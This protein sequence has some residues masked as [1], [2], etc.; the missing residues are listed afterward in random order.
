MSNQRTTLLESELDEIVEVL[1][2]FPIRSVHTRLI[3]CEKPR[4]VGEANSF[5]EVENEE[6]SDDVVIARSIFDRFVTR[7][8]HGEVLQASLELIDHVESIE[9][10]V[11]L[12][13][14]DW[15]KAHPC[16]PPNICD[17]SPA[18]DLPDW[19]FSNKNGQFSLNFASNIK[20]VIESAVVALN[21][22]QSMPEVILTKTAKKAVFRDVSWNPYVI[23]ATTMADAEQFPY[24][25]NEQYFAW[26]YLVR[27]RVGLNGDYGYKERLN[28]F[29]GEGSS[30]SSLNISAMMNSTLEGI[31]N[32]KVVEIVSMGLKKVWDAVIGIIGFLTDSY[33]SFLEK[34]RSYLVTAILKLFDVEAIKQGS[35]EIFNTA[36]LKTTILYVILFFIGANVL[37]YSLISYFAKRSSSVF[38]GEADISPA[39]L[40]VTLAAGVFGLTKGQEDKVAK[41]ARYLVT[42]M[43]GGTVLANLG[44]CA[45]SL[46]PS[47]IQDSLAW[48]FG[49][50]EYRLKYQVN[51]WRS[52]AN[53]LLQFSTVPRVVASPYFAQQI[54][55][56]LKQGSEILD[57]TIG[58]KFTALRSITLGVYMRLQKIRM[59]LNQYRTEG[60]KRAEPFVMHMFGPPGVG[61]T[62]LAETIIKRLGYLTWYEKTIDDDFFSGYLDQEVLL[63]DEFLVGPPESQQKTASMFLTGASSAPWRVNQ[64][65]MD[66]PIVG[67]KG[68]CFNCKAIVTLNN[69]PYP[70]VAGFDDT[71]LQRRRDVVVECR[72][73]PSCRKFCELDGQGRKVLIMKKVPAEILRSKEHLQFRMINP[74]F[75]P[76]WESKATPWCHFEILCKALQSAHTTKSEISE[77]LCSDSTDL[78]QDETPPEE[79]I[80]AEIRKTCVLPSKPVGVLDA[81]TSLFVSK[82]EE[83]VAEGR[84]KRKKCDDCGSFGSEGST[85]AI[86]SSK[87]VVPESLPDLTSE[88]GSEEPHQEAQVPPD[89]WDELIK[90][91][92]DDTQSESTC[93]NELEPWVDASF[94]RVYS[95]RD[96]AWDFGMVPSRAYI[97]KTCSMKSRTIT[98]LLVGLLVGAMYGISRWLR[99]DE[100][101]KAISFGAESEPRSKVSHRSKGGKSRWTR[102]AMMHGEGPASIETC[103]LTLDSIRVQVIPI[104][105][106]WLMTFAHCLFAGGKMLSPGTSVSLNYRDHEYEWKYNPD[107]VS[108]CK[109]P[110]TGEIVHDLLF[111]KVGNPKCPQFKSIVSRF[112]SDDQFPEQGF[113]MMMRTK[114]GLRWSSARRDVQPYSYGG[115][116][117]TLNDGF[118]YRTLTTVGDC[119]SPI[120]LSSGPNIG[121]CAGIHVAG[122][123]DKT[124]PVGLAVRVSK[125]M[126]LEAIGDELET[127][128]F[129]AEA[130]FMDRLAVEN[131]TNLKSIQK[132]T[133][134]ERIHMCDKTKL[135]PS[136]IAPFL[137]WKSKKQPSVMSRFDPR[138]G[139]KDPVE[140]SIVRIATAPK[141]KLDSVRLRECSLEMIANLKKQLDYSKTG[142]IRELSFE[143]A[144]FGIPGALSPVVTSTSAGS[145]YC[146]F[147]RKR[148]KRELVW[149]IESEG[150]YNPLFKEHVLAMY[151]RV[152]RG[153]SF[154]KVFIGYMKDEVRSESKIQN[155]NTRITFAD[156][157]TYNVVCRMLFGSM[158]VAFNT[159]FPKHAYA[160]GINPGSY[161][162]MKILQRVRFFDDRLIDGDFPEFDIRH[163]RQI[164]DESF[165][166]LKELG[167]ALD[168][169]GVIFDHVREHETCVPL[170]MGDWKIETVCNNPS[171][172]FWTTILNCLTCEQ[173][174]R[175]TF[176]GRYPGKIFDD[177]IRLV[178]L[179]DDN[180]VS[181]HRQ[182]EWNPLMIRE[183]MKQVGQGYTSSVKDR[184]LDENYHTFDDI[185]FLGHHPKLVNGEYS[186]ALRKETLEGSLLWTRN[187]NLTI[188]DE[189]QQ[190]VEYASQWDKEYFEYFQN[191]VNE[192]LSS[193]GLEELGLPPWESLRVIVANR[194]ADSGES[195]RFRGEAED[196]AIEQSPGLTTVV[197]GTAVESIDDHEA[198]DAPIERAV[199]EV[200]ANLEMGPSSFVKR[201]QIQWANGSAE[202]SILS[203]TALPYGLLGLG[204]QNNLQ[205]MPF[206][207]FLLSRPD[208]EIMVQLNGAPTQAGCLI[209]FFVPLSPIIPEMSNWIMM[210][211]V[212]LSPADNPTGTLRLPFQYWQTMLDNQWAH[213]HEVVTGYLH[214]GVYAN[215]NT[216]S[217]PSDC[218][219]TVYSKVTTSSRIPRTMPVSTTGTRPVYG[220]TMGTGTLSGRLLSSDTRFLAEGPNIS[221]T[222][223]TNQYTVGSVAGSMPVQAPV[224]V[225]GSK[226][227]ASNKVDASTLPL[228]NPPLVGGS[229]PTMNQ[230]CSM[231][232]ANGPEVTIGLGLHPEEMHRQ[233]LSFR[234]P[235][236]STI[237]GLCGRFGRITSFSWSVTQADGT[238]LLTLDLCSL[239][240]DDAH[241]L[242]WFNTTQLPLNVAILNLFKF[243]H[244]DVVYR[245]HAVRTKFH[246]G[247]LMASVGY[248]STDSPPSLKQALYNQIMDF[249]GDSSVAEIV[250]P[251]NNTQEYICAFDNYRGHDGASRFA[252]VFVSVLNELRAANE[253][254]ADNVTV[255]VEIGFQNVR[256][257]VP[258]GY[259]PMTLGGDQSRIVMFKAEG[260]EPEDPNVAENRMVVTAT[261]PPVPNPSCRVELGEKFEYNV[262]DLHE[263]LR[264]YN[265]CPFA[266]A[267]RQ[268]VYDSL[269]KTSSYEVISIAV[270][271]QCELAQIFAAW[272]GTMK[273]RIYAESNSYCT[274]TYMPTRSEVD[275]ST[276]MTGQTAYALA[277]HTSADDDTW[278]QAPVFPP[279]LAREVM[280]PIGSMSFIDVSVPFYT[281]RNM[282]P[283]SRDWERAS[284]HVNQFP[285]G[286]ANGH[287]LI[288]VPT[289]TKIHVYWAAGDDFRFHCLAPARGVRV[290]L[291]ARG[292]VVDDG[293]SSRGYTVCGIYTPQP[294]PA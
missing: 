76:D 168:P 114:D 73:A 54:Q 154:D 254:V 249:N 134:A 13:D 48:K 103:W 124:E 251:Y 151:H 231:S 286:S 217:L 142:G 188:R 279:Y 52:S 255:I 55:E 4:F 207:N 258:T 180:I 175:Y 167:R 16:P 105:G 263:V 280:Y 219:V 94:V 44:A 155:V 37:S 61:K 213:D 148:G 2:E 170:L 222:N 87:N 125:E 110:T 97:E 85:C 108:C 152:K 86:C 189:C 57:E 14:R 241:R 274:V 191:S 233:P 9:D 81:M 278:C 248:G 245:F 122:T 19:K 58:P 96:A 236:E 77:V 79:L 136:V 226:Q 83:F 32:C 116:M 75:S 272:S 18:F 66:D 250:V 135:K 269:S 205:N 204:D 159:S 173:Y 208:I 141:V 33:H 283:T 232:K 214:L 80:N 228:D 247:R 21:L 147:V 171:G 71:A 243:I 271:P 123:L 292:D 201:F 132:T 275:W 285:Q 197:T 36:V 198:G 11:P 224:K 82:E 220:F 139:G 40:V 28:G 193:V 206:Q 181:V 169:S 22:Q 70:R 157:V 178:I 246:S 194:T 42:L 84:R 210:P 111:I 150:K 202:G 179:G 261:V 93:Y 230:F 20:K 46:L 6:K 26:L 281:Q 92:D 24:E 38:V 240:L 161:D 293:P 265:F 267:N 239:F 143:E 64:P 25:G 65:S 294:L 291:G 160:I 101:D 120:M 35:S 273:Y 252:S 234:D 200:S 72:V 49:S 259:S 277:P 227:S 158:V 117:L 17:P 8:R 216:K 276:I 289:D 115:H 192:A 212:K 163:Q 238:D 10:D 256:V 146:Y 215:V 91:D 183:D 145:P 288:R 1:K 270:T 113:D 59:R 264:R 53:A 62:L 209:A 131:C 41:R 127:G 118:R 211:H 27:L 30:G 144:L 43:A 156:D 190:M 121:M 107:E 89:S 164:M 199:S 223:V 23:Y 99:G 133:F 29:V 187:S 88:D 253:V 130:P 225:G 51:N 31:K 129:V 128:A 260:E 176:K 196:T 112:L 7:T 237:E 90:T 149:H 138:A 95:D 257:A 229:V 221:T 242:N 287:L 69:S 284:D 174:F 63:L 102:G 244:C 172:G 50:K 235:S 266:D 106:R 218:G 119:G 56:C 162:F 109:D 195:Y 203:T 184:E 140:E 98:V 74:L 39:A 104:A 5:V 78:Y 47:V 268:T 262:K 186:G 137:P 3:K 34:V 68:Q 166:I 182:V 126:I 290:K 185:L 153:E 282:L 100:S 67:V 15:F 12:R 177:F 45:F 60:V 165:F